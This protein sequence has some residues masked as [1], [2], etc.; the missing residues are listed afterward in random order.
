[1]IYAFLKN[2]WYFDEIY[3]VLIVRPALAFGRFLWKD[4]DGKTI[5]GV[6]PPATTIDLYVDTEDEG[7]VYLGAEYNG[8]YEDALTRITPREMSIAVPLVILAIVFGVYPQSVFR[9]MS[10]SV[11]QTVKDLASWKQRHELPATTVE[12]GPLDHVPNIAV[13]DNKRPAEVGPNATTET[14]VAAN[15]ANS[16]SENFLRRRALA[17]GFA[18]EPDASASRLNRLPAAANISESNTNTLDRHRDAP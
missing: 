18:N 12:A 3:D 4:G 10:P 11:D 7:R 8:P 16:Q 14:Q 15:N 9:Y 17:P 5:D 6:G 13:N 2:K 1:M